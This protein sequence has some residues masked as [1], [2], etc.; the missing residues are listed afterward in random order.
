LILQAF[1][2]LMIGLVTR[3][4]SRRCSQSCVC[5]GLFSR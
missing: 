3:S 2:S 4:T 5:R 1:V